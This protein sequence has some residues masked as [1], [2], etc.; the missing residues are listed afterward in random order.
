M[1]D[2]VVNME[3]SGDDLDRIASL[4]PESTWSSVNHTTYVPLRFRPIAIS[5]ETKT[6]SRTEEEARVQLAIWVAALLARIRQLMLSQRQPPPQQQQP[7]TPSYPAPG[8]AEAQAQAEAEVDALLTAIIFPLLYVQNE[9]WHVFFARASVP[10]TSNHSSV[11][12]R[13]G[14]RG[15]L[16]ITV[17]T[18][19]CLGDTNNSVNTYALLKGLQR[20]FQWVDVEFRMWWK[21]AVRL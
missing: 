14:G 21:G 9:K 3:W 4:L 15:E 18:S 6:I 10:A 13:P 19:L 5:I 11:R 7:G 16:R 2:Y 12:P 17:Y 8:L 1:V 20:L